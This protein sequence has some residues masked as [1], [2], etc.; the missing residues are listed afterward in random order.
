MK[1]KEYKAILEAANNDIELIQSKYQIAKKQRKIDNLV[2]WMM[3]AIQEEYSEPV[4]KRK[5]TSFNNIGAR[6]YDYNEL[7]RALLSH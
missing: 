3:K 7:E 4:E 6:E 1:T 5:A 2:G